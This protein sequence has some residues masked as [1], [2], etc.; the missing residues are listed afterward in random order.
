LAEKINMNISTQ[1]L[2]VNPFSRVGRKLDYILALI[3]HNNGK[4]RQSPEGVREYFD[5]LKLQDPKNKDATFGSTPY[6]IRGRTIIQT[7][8][9]DE[10]G[11]HVGS[12]K[13]DPVSGRVYTDWARAKFGD[14]AVNPLI[15][16]NSC[17]IG[18]ELCQEDDE[19]HFAP[20]TLETAAEL[21]ADICIRRK[22]H[23]IRDVGTHWMVVGWK[24]CPLWW[25]RH[26]EEFQ[27]FQ[28]TILDRIA[29]TM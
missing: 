29:D 15:S 26:P 24:E 4:A 5:G 11:W 10:V 16:P 3:F 6:I 23:P 14:Y 18:I 8:D 25:T 21:A 1:Y 19:G 27:R 9:E 2:T 12:D 20:E 7:M 28:T 22:L 13:H 17:T